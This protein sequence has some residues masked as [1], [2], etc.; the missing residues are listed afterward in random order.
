[1]LVRRRQG[2][3]GATSLEFWDGTLKNRIYVELRRAIIMGRRPPGAKI[4]IREIA[5]HYGTS[6]TPIREAL[7]MLHQEGLVTIRP[8]SGYLVTQLTLKQLRDLFELR[9]IL[10]LAAVERAARRITEKQIDE[11]EGVYQG[12]TGDDDES[13]DRYTAENRRFHCLI[14]QATGNQELVQQL[15]HLHDRLA[16]F[17][18]ARRAG[19]AMQQSHDRIVEALRSGDADG[20]RQ[21]LLDELAD[22][23]EYVLDHVIQEQGGSW[24][25]GWQRE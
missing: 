21:A 20:A 5:G 7:Q 24:R 12:Y 19:E 9:E 17:M 1:V 23:R 2:E 8:H 16:R 25:L 13:Y 6:I 10:E 4:D 18:V 11:L 3:E 22:T 15:G 14:A